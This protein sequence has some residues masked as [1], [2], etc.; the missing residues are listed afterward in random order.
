MTD[1]AFSAPPALPTSPPDPVPTAAPVRAPLAMAGLDLTADRALVERLDAF[2]REAAGA[3]P[4]NTVSAVRS[5]LRVWARWCR[6]E[7]HTALPAEPSAVAAFLDDMARDRKRATVM[8]YQTSLAF[9]HTALDL[10][11]PTKTRLVRFTA[12]RLRRESDGEQTQAEPLRARDVARIL[13]ATTDETLSDCRDRAMLLVASDLL[14]RASELVSLEVRDLRR[15]P[16]G[17]TTATIRRSKTDQEGRGAVGYLAP[18]T[19][20]AVDR[21]RTRAGIADGRLFRGLTRHGH[22]AAALDRDWVSV[23]FRQL[24]TRA[25]LEPERVQRVSGHS[26]RIGT[27][28]DLAAAGYALN[29]IMVAGRWTSPQMVIRYTRHLLAEQNAVAQFRQ[30]E[31]QSAGRPTKHGAGLAL[32]VAN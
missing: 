8:R 2:T 21:W 25:G 30:A 9:L 27:A 23:A 29:A 28:Q 24:A 17:A 10:P 13:A 22:V 11:D 19:V 14:A 7:G 12:R 20:S 15:N 18:Q 26:C 16:S 31:A 3:F 5:D 1:A 32:A 4:P 6:A